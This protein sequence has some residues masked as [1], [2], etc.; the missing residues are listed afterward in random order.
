[1][2][3][4]GAGSGV[5]A[6]EHVCASVAAQRWRRGGFTPSE[7]PIRHNG[8]VSEPL[9]FYVRDKG[10]RVAH[11]FDYRRSRRGYALCGHAYLDEIVWEGEQ[12]PRAVCRACQALVGPY[13]LRWWRSRAEDLG[14]QLSDLD[15]SHR[16]LVRRYDELKQHAENQRR[17]LARYQRKLTA[18]AGEGR[19]KAAEQT[20]RKSAQ[21]PR[22]QNVKKRRRTRQPPPIVVV[23]GGLPGLGKRR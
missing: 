7:V 14:R 4:N 6:F 2:R 8:W 18:T 13:E 16:E 20:S 17:E 11:H 9:F 21:S 10:S 5:N 1:M 19:P 12:R 3:T 15:G 22:L 23:S